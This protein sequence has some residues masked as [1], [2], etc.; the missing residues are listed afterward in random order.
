MKTKCMCPQRT[1]ACLPFTNCALI[2]FMTFCYPLQGNDS[3]REG[4]QSFRIVALSLREYHFKEIVTA[5][6]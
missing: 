6:R 2:V 5:V 1:G 3:V 4:K